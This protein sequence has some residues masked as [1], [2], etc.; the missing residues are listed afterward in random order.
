MICEYFFIEIKK[1][2]SSEI[3][4]FSKVDD[5]LKLFFNIQKHKQIYF[6]RVNLYT[7]DR[8]ESRD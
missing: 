2:Q 7:L 3:Y 1:I 8:L 5:L 6:D 4:E